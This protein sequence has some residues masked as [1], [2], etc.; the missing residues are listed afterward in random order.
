MVLISLSQLLVVIANFYTL[1]N[2]PIQCACG[3]MIFKTEV[4]I[5]IAAS[6]FTLNCKLQKYTTAK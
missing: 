5:F 6:A 2:P 1:F 4:S 3:K